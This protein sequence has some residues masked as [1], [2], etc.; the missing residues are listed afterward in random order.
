MEPINISA[1]RPN[2][3]AALKWPAM[4]DE[5]SDESL[6]Q[7]FADG[8]AD[9]FE[10]LYARHRSGLFRF[11]LRQ[12]KQTTLTEELFQDVWQRV[13]AAR[14][15]YRPDARFSTWLYA[16][17]HNRLNDHWRAQRHRPEPPADADLRLANAPS[18]DNPE[19]NL[20]S[21]EQRRRLQLAIEALPPEQR[22]VLVLRLEQCLSMA[23]IATITGAGRE[24]VK[25]RLRYAMDKLRERLQP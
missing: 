4:D 24:T 6:M 7:A 21:F 15:R 23:E 1:P 22:E 25:S 5:I 10:T 19:R 2:D 8:Q 17:A 13:I 18:T 11:L 14:A 16:I 9:A 20:S 12:L 3:A